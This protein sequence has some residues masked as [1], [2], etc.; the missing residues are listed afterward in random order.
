MRARHD[1]D[2]LVHPPAGS[3]G[4]TAGRR[5]RVYKSEQ[6]SGPKMTLLQTLKPRFQ[7]STVITN[8]L[9]MCFVAM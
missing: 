2:Q 5:L 6:A 1:A 4:G 3:V 7:I 8:K 9:T